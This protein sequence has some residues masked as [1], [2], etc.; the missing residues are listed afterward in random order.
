MG[1][2]EDFWNEKFTEAFING[3]EPTKFIKEMLPRMQKGKTLDIGMGEGINATYFAKSGFK[4]KGLDI[5][6]KA[7]EHAKALALEMGVEIE[8]QKTDLDL[9]IT[10]LMEYDSI[11]MT[12][13]KPPLGRYYSELIRALKQ[14]G[15]LLVESYSEEEKS[16][17]IHPEEAYRDY[18]FRSNELL[19]E[20]KGM[21]ILYY[22][23]SKI[24]G[25]HVIQCLAKKP[26]DKDAAKYNLFD[27]HSEQKKQ[28]PS[29][30]WELAE[31][32]FKKKD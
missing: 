19:K 5:S 8:I 7:I 21:R 12:F 20:L 14:G 11:I 32:L 22:N 2:A 23:E 30:Q 9:F 29:K 31:S 15:T 10:G 16:E 3:K 25:K 1:K 26:L 6:A 13:F 4:V 28:G 18:F 24:N 17:V 27:M